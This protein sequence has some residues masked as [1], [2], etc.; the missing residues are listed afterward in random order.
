MYNEWIGI[1]KLQLES[2]P[3]CQI[4]QIPAGISGGVESTVELSSVGMCLRNI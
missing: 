3:F 4:M 1:P 2:C